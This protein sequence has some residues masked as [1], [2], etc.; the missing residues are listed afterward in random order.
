MRSS[1]RSSH[2]GRFRP[3]SVRHAATQ[4]YQRT[5][6]V[7]VYDSSYRH[8]GD[9]HALAEAA[10]DRRCN[11]HGG[12]DG[13]RGRTWGHRATG[14]SLCGEPT[15]D[16][17]ERPVARQRLGSRRR[18][19]DAVV[20]RRQRHELVDV[21]HRR[22]VEE[23]ADGERAGRTPPGSCSTATRTTSS[24]TRTG[25]ADLPASSLPPKPARA[26]LVAHGERDVA[27]PPS[28][29]GTA[30]DLQGPCDAERPAYATASTTTASTSSTRR[31]LR[32]PHRSGSALPK[33]YAPF[34]IQ[35]LGGNI[36][37]TYAKQDRR[38]R[39]TSP[40]EGRLR[41]RV[42]ARR[43]V[44][45]RAPGRRR[46]RRRVTWAPG[47]RAQRPDPLLPAVILSSSA[48]LRNGLD[49]RWTRT[50]AAAHW[51]YSASS[52]KG[53][54]EHCSTLD[55]LLG[56]RQLYAGAVLV[57]SNSPT[58]AAGRRR[59]APRLRPLS[60]PQSCTCPPPDDTIVA[61]EDTGTPYARAR[62]RTFAA[63]VL[64]LGGE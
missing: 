12:R 23:P 1:E 41:R 60:Q 26:G 10:P 21:V 44:V 36:F 64:R 35:A 28:T 3:R 32:W 42:H 24:S 46:Q 53:A 19:D 25:R 39:M 7:L 31:S 63:A 11:R 18:S 16:G 52:W 30:R 8:E 4:E 49:Q 62:R 56:T 27:L 14:E 33:G 50:A 15:L 37:V 17:R 45:A 38:A 61:P 20:D 58:L 54:T 59:A 13:S 40:A 34:G 51:V 57:R 43:A 47:A 22:R 5:R 6:G 55:G 48:S 2:S 29:R 9:K